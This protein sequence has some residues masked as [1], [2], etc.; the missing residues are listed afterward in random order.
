MQLPQAFI[1][2]EPGI[3]CEQNFCADG[4]ADR[5]ALAIECFQPRHASLTNFALPIVEH[6]VCCVC[7]VVLVGRF[8]DVLNR[9]STHGGNVRSDGRERSITTH[10]PGRETIAVSPLVAK[11]IW[12]EEVM[13]N[14]S[15]VVRDQ[16]RRKRL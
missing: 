6:S 8:G 16:C 14:R 9:P 1:H 13:Y 15:L 10:S 5:R 7:A 3:H 11:L 12:Q 2:L 4:Q